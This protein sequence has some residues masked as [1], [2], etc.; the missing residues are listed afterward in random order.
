M[1]ENVFDTPEMAERW[2]QNAALRSAYL[3][4]A[5]ERMLDAA[6]VVPGARVLDLGTGTGDTALLAAARVGPAGHVLATDVAPSMVSATQQ[7]V[8][9]A[10][11]ENVE[12]RAADAAALDLEAA[13][14]D[15]VIA[16]FSLMFIPDIGPALAGIRRVARHGGRLAALVWGPG[17]A[18]PCMALAPGVARRTGRL[19]IPEERA[20]APLRLGDRDAL[21]AATRD[22]G[23]KE[24]AVE[25]IALE[26]RFPDANAAFEA[27]WSSPLATAVAGEL[28]GDELAG[29]QA[30][31][32]AEVEARGL[33]YPGLALL[34]RARNLA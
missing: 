19:R 31:L 32:R 34:L 25:G 1:S 16:R 17:E 10:G 21:A 13:A 6:G 26:R 20:T 11:L 30:D 9:E 22:A 8:R 3:K 12:V 4:E 18:N 15:A 28:Q 7:A 33:T 14:Y 24:V 23:W 2:R 29:Y 5:T 27:I